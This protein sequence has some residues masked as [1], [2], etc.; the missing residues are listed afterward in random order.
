[1]PEDAV[2]TARATLAVGDR[3]IAR[4]VLRPLRT[5]ED[6][7]DRTALRR[8]AGCYARWTGELPPG[9]PGDPG[10]DATP[11]AS[12]E[13][14]GSG[15]DPAAVVLGVIEGLWGI[16][17]EAPRGAVTVMP[18]LPPGWNEMALRR[19]RVGPTTL[20]LRVRRRPG[21]TVVMIRR[22]AGPAIRLTVGLRGPRRPG[23][24]TID[25]IEMGGPEVTFTAEDAHQVD[26]HDE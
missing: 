4:D 2:G 7:A 22:T 8:L 20:D 21:R 12:F 24:V 25:E 6:G 16:R 10:E 5:D 19:L 14:A 15:A 11:E 18:A 17:P 1:V 3:D 13:L 23:P 26:F 9:V